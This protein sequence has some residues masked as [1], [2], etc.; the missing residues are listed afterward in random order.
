MQHAGVVQVLSTYV[1]TW[2]ALASH[3]VMGGATYCYQP[4]TVHCVSSRLQL[5]DR[6]KGFRGIAGTRRPH[7]LWLSQGCHSVHLTGCALRAGGRGALLINAVLSGRVVGIHPA[8][9]TAPSHRMLVH[10]VCMTACFSQVCTVV[11]WTGL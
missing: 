5:T 11:L 9:C 1:D 6:F 10:V 7:F 2:R 4:L 3:W 8:C